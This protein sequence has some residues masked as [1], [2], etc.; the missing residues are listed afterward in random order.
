VSKITDKL[1]AIIYMMTLIDMPN[2]KAVAVKDSK[3]LAVGSSA[4]IPQFK[5]NIAVAITFRTF[6]WARGARPHKCPCPNSCGYS[7]TTEIIDL[8]GKVIV[9]RFIDAHGHTFGQG[10]ATTVAGL[11]LPPD[12][13]DS[14]AKLQDKLRTWSQIPAAVRL[15]CRPRLR[16]FPKGATPSHPLRAGCLFTEIPSRIT[17]QRGAD[18]LQGWLHDLIVIKPIY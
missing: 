16:R 18:N 15:D 1:W 5:S 10:I 12:D 11:L 14:I 9:P 17:H 2:A 13:V 3:I 4:E 6:M 7:Y 8:N